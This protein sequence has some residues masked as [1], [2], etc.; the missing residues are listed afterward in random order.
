MQHLQRRR[1]LKTLAA[2]AFAPTLPVAVAQTASG[3]KVLRYAFDQGENG[4]DPAQINDIYSRIVT[5]H[6]FEGLYGYDYLARP[7]KIKPFTA[8]AMPEVSDDFRTWTIRLKPGIYFQD[9]PAF[10]GQR[11]ELIAQDYVYS[12]KRFA[13][14]RWKSPAYASIADLRILGLA[15]L[16]DEALKTGKPFDYDREIEGMRA[17]DRYTLQF[18]LE[19]P[20]PRSLLQVLA[21]PDLWG[22]VAREVVETYGDKIMEHPVGTGPFRLAQWRRSSL[23]V[24]ERNPTY[25]EVLYDAEPNADDADGRALAAR[26]SGR[27]LPMVDRVEIAIIDEQQPRWLSF[28]NMQQDLL[29]RLPFEFINIAAPN[30]QLAPNLARRGVQMQRTLNSDRFYTYFNMDD[31]VV[32]G[33]TPEKIALR[34]AISM[35]FDIEQEIRLFWRGQAVPAQSS[36]APHLSGYDPAF[37]VDGGGYD[38]PRARALLDTYGYVDRDGDGWREQPDGSPLVIEWSTTPEQRM[39]L[40]DDLR[41]KDMAKLGIRVVFKVGRFQENLKNGR[42]GK[43]MMWTLGASSAAPDGQPGLDLG[44]TVHFGGQNF[45]RFS[46]PRFDEIYARLRE[47]PDGPEREQLFREAK[48]ILAVYAPYKVQV[49]RILTDFAWPWLTGYRRPLFTQTWW[50]Y[51]DI[52]VALRQRETGA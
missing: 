43:L 28:L 22:A 42:A 30:G 2:A 39:R 31:P 45:A 3:V 37:R 36:V 24:L 40:R 51:V 7:Y 12:I 35:G 13:D 38:L 23:I 17:P 25:R 11:R 1:A 20:V 18:R 16:R 50:Q 6:L 27:K 34:R 32:G 33:Y 41:R 4:F 14:P 44:A 49:H 26:F 10:K 15:A 8:A 46:N 9:D 19:R 52:D 5:G 21:T 47:L 48:R 29:E